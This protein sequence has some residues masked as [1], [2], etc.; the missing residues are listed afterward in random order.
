MEE[1]ESEQGDEGATWAGGINDTAS[2]A[3]YCIRHVR[4]PF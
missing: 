4:H 3:G 2:V 1:R